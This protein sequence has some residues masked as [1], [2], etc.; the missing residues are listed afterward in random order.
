M[1]KRGESFN[2]MRKKRRSR[3]FNMLQLH[4]YRSKKNRDRAWQKQGRRAG[5][6]KEA[7]FVDNMVAHDIT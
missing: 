5:A 2:L 1:I 3:V 7:G 6:R 4:G